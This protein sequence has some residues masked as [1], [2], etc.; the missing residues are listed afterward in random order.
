MHSRKVIRYP[1][2]KPRFC[3][4]KSTVGRENTKNLPTWLVWKPYKPTQLGIPPHL[5]PFGK[6]EVNNLERRSYILPFLFWLDIFLFSFLHG[7]MI[8]H[9]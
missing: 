2:M 7:F 9:T 3:K 6:E 4:L 5:D 8:S 1:G